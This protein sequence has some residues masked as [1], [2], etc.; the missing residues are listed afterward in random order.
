MIR[1]MCQG[2]GLGCSKGWQYGRLLAIL[3]LPCGTA[4]RWYR[5][6][7]ENPSREDSSLAG[8]QLHRHHSHTTAASCMVH[9]LLMVD[10]LFLG[11]LCYHSPFFNYNP[12]R[13]SLAD[14][15]HLYQEDLQR[16]FL[17]VFAQSLGSTHRETCNRVNPD[18]AETTFEW[19]QACLLFD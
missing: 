6:G 19:K 5:G 10:V 14:Q 7:G 18:F 13:P 12:A 4:W 17:E 2:T 15:V 1:D 8:P 3:F 9:K 16:G 11:H